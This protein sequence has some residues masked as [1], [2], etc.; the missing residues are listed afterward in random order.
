MSPEPE[1]T[2]AQRAALDHVRAVARAATVAARARLGATLGGTAAAGPWLPARARVAVH[3]HPDRVTAD[4]RTVAAGLLADGRYR[5]QFETGISN[6]G[7]MAWPGSDRD[8]WEERLFGGA[9]HVPGVHVPE[10]PKYGALDLLGHPDGPAPRFGSCYLRLRPEVLGRSTFSC[11]DSVTHPEDLGTQDEFAPVLAGLLEAVAGGWTL[12]RPGLDSSLLHRS[13]REDGVPS[14]R[15]VAGRCLD[16]Y[17]EAHVHGEVRMDR[18]VELLV[19]DPSFRGTPAG[20]LLAATARRHRVPL[21]WHL[22]FHLRFHEVPGDFRGPAMPGLARE[23]AGPTGRV[24]AAAV[25]VAAAA[26]CT[27]PDRLQQL[28]YLWHVL[29]RFGRPTIRSGRYR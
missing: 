5:T 18:D 12:G 10:R 16:E 23:V 14:V 2:F 8:G 11:G 28:K 13:L 29:V 6:G 9:F 7:L 24:D 22:G 4:G 17:V 25:G 3:F 21:A 20:D 26:A 1:L 27:D 15:P 19:A